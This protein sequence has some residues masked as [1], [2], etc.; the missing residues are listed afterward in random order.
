M[1][2][3]ARSNP[4]RINIASSY[5]VL[6]GYV[7]LD[8][9]PFFR[10]GRLPNWAKRFIPVK[11][12][13]TVQTY[14]QA[15]QAA[16][17]ILHDCRKPL[18]FEGQSVQHALCSHFLEHVPRVEALGVLH[19]IFRVLQPGGTLHLIVPDLA[20]Q[21]GKY[22]EATNRGDPVASERFIRGL[23]MKSEHPPTLLRRALDLIGSYGL[24]HWWMYDR[25]SLKCI[26]GE[27]GFSEC[28]GL[29]FDS[30]DYRKDDPESLHM[31]CKKPSVA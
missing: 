31:F 25:A 6:A 29:D 23:L 13:E 4:I 20:Y 21:V 5:E 16:S 11:Y 14:Y 2:V 27:A 9:S 15:D 24:E 10:L 30:S 8:S 26:V 18:P 22:Q 7:N 12:R 28:S 19:E 3:I 17:V 1:K